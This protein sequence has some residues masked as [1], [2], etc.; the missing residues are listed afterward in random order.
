M[1]N[2]V[3]AESIGSAHKQI[4]D[5]I[6]LHG[7]HVITEDSEDT[8]ELDSPL[9]VQVHMPL[10]DPMIYRLPSGFAVCGFN[11]NYMEEYATQMMN[12]NNTNNFS[13]TYGSR[14]RDYTIDGLHID[15][16]ESVIEKIAR[17]PSTR[18]AIM[19]TWD[20]MNDLNGHHVPCIQTIQ[21]LWRD[22]YINCVA[23]I[24]SND[25]LMAWGCNA[26]GLAR[27]MEVA[28]AKLSSEYN[29]LTRVGTLTTISSSAHIY[30]DR[31]ADVLERLGYG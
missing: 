12:P 31:D 4:I 7:K 8:V 17:H 16:F 24:R 3:S 20:V 25:M 21:F 23:T 22:T 29:L 10:Y 27:M 19:H 13:Y 28:A 11:K 14:L 5:K 2:A 15:Q 9:I 6:M 18:R 30:Y 1:I 26:Y